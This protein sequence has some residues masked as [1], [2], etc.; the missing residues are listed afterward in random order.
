MGDVRNGAMGTPVEAKRPD[1]AD[2]V[3]ARGR[4]SVISF[5]RPAKRNAITLQMWGELGQIVG[6]LQADTS[7]RAIVLTGGENFSAG[8][9]ISEFGDVR[10]NAGQAAKYESVVEETLSRLYDCE[11]PTIAAISGY[12]LGGG[13][14]LAQAC[15]FR[16]ADSTAVFSVPAAKLGIV[17]NAHECRSLVSIVG[18]TN[19]KHILFT[20]ERFNAAH[21]A[22]IGF[23][24]LV[25]DG[26]A[27]QNA[28]HLGTTLAANAPLSISGMKFIVNCLSEG[29]VEE[30]Q[31]AIAS[32]IDEALESRDYREAVA[33]FREKRKVEFHGV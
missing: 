22:R 1:S 10:A 31:S 5:N 6:S 23:V 29:S 25:H 27:L 17:Y 4:V 8:A 2:I 21:A 15:D 11:K 9:D 20:G 33:A 26:E 7:V 3:V 24:E 28:K 18:A 32:K 12:C 14:A 16:I 19:A 30:Y 13:M